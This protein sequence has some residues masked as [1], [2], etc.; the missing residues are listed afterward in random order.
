MEYEDQ[1]RDMANTDNGGYFGG[2]SALAE[3]LATARDRSAA[4]NV[5]PTNS[6]RLITNIPELR[7]QATTYIEPQPAAKL[8]PASGGNKLGDFLSNYEKRLQETPDFQ[9]KQS[10]INELRDD[11][12]QR[13]GN[14]QKATQKVVEDSMNLTPI[15]HAL[16]KAI[17][18]D[19]RDRSLEGLDS[20]ET[21]KL[22]ANVLKL[23]EESRK[24]S[25]DILKNSPDLQRFAKAVDSTI[26]QHEKL[27]E[28]AQADMEKLAQK[29]EAER[30]T[31][32]IGVAMLDPAAR[33]AV[34][35]INPEMK[36]D[37]AFY[38]FI[39]KGGGKNKDWA[40]IL[41]G[42][43]KD[44]D[45]VQAAL[46]TNNLPAKMLAISE[47]SARSGRDPKVVDAEFQKL[48]TLSKNPALALEALQKGGAFDGP[49]GSKRL[50]DLKAKIT[51]GDATT[52]KEVTTSL[53]SMLP[54]LSE[55]NAITEIRNNPPKEL[56]QNPE[57]AAMYQVTSEKKGAPAN[58]QEVGQAWMREPNLS[59]E[60]R[61]RR[62]DVLVQAYAKEVDRRG[63]SGIFYQMDRGK[64]ADEA[65][66]MKSALTANIVRDTFLSKAGALFGDTARG[67][68]E[69]NFINQAF[70]AQEQGL[71]KQY[72]LLDEFVQGMMG[73]NK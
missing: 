61:L 43:I 26:T 59:N 55:R 64:V 30:E 46:T 35:R 32:S 44:T 54:A 19:S 28:K 1:L 9:G 17:E 14:A 51:L 11:A 15:R 20:P 36:D 66:K 16:N 41:L 8:Q 3:M 2:T 27:A 70:Q 33:A 23:E 69:I 5:D 63:Q 72:G 13:M 42:E 38:N 57:F 49:E 37:V 53:I 50:K 48:E 68:G 18:L 45:Y 71:R 56:M 21:A 4:A 39:Q 24:T 22:R 58:I 6:P 60:E 62:Q 25:Q 29:K 65:R 12:M 73:G 10:I 40:P 7:S 31:A 34:T 67:A 47:E 52:R